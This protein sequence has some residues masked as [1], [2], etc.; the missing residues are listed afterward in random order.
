M[1]VLFIGNSHTFFNDMPE[2]LRLFGKARNIDIEVVQNTAGGRGLEWQANQFDVRFNILFGNY[3]YI[4]LQHIAHP[5]P[6]KEHLLEGAALLMPY[7][8]KTDSK[9]VNYHTWSEKALPEKQA[10]INEAHSALLEQYPDMLSAPVGL[11]W[12]ELRHSHPEIELYYHDGEH[13]APLG[14]YL[15]AATFFRLLTGERAESLP[16]LLEMGKPT[17]A[18]LKLEKTLEQDF[19]GPTAYDLDPVACTVI[20]R[21]VDKRTPGR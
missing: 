8:A 6:G 21:T 2:M 7:L 18:G 14:S 17:F 10:E 20:A 9:V 5:F 3:D 19:N 13:A 16:F 12:D 4:V 11:I 1:K 15:I